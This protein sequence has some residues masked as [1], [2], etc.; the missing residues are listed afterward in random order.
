MLRGGDMG[1]RMRPRKRLI[2]CVAALLLATCGCVDLD[3]ITQIAKVS[4]DIGTAFPVFADEA[5]ASCNRA[6]EQTVLSLR[7]SGHPSTL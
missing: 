5:A 7:S 1:E 3:E 2:A 4:Q 6:N